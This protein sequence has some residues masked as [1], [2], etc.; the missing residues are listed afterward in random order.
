MNE[1][2]LKKLIQVTGEDSIKDQIAL[3][4]NFSFDR[5]SQ[6]FG[7]FGPNDSVG[8][9]VSHASQF[10][11]NSTDKYGTRDLEG[12]KHNQSKVS[13]FVK[14][15]LKNELK[16]ENKSRIKIFTGPNTFEGSREVELDQKEY[17]IMNTVRQILKREEGKS[18]YDETSS[19]HYSRKTESKESTTA[20]RERLKNK[21]NNLRDKINTSQNNTIRSDQ[22]NFRVPMNKISQKSDTNKHP[23][24]TMR[25]HSRDGSKSIEGSWLELDEFVNS[26]DDRIKDKN[27]Y[28]DRI[29]NISSKKDT[30]NTVSYQGE[31]GR[32]ANTFHSKKRSDNKGRPIDNLNESNHEIQSYTNTKTLEHY[33]TIEDLKNS[34]EGDNPHNPNIIKGN[35]KEKSKERKRENSKE[36]VKISSLNTTS[37]L[38]KQRKPYRFQSSKASNKYSSSHKNKRKSNYSG[39]SS[40][41]NKSQSKKCKS[42]NK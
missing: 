35:Y 18:N 36:I 19:N 2:N 39:N 27:G 1:R 9:K 24:E 38:Q 23:V 26:W 8:N 32:S 10:T 41:N 37:H 5:N 13:E 30:F 3:K 25:V 28:L 40:F 42:S 6:I 16:H 12:Y 21:I 4:A 33:F 17:P 7:A 22:D 11:F 20:I 15:S 29:V 31:S 14:D 34:R